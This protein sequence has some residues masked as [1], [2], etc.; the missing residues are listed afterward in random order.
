MAVSKVQNHLIL[1]L[2]TDGVAGSNPAARTTLIF[3]GL[4]INRRAIAP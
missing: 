1:I 2:H 3:N 4:R